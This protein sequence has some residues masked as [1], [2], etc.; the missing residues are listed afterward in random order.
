MISFV[1]EASLP[2]IFMRS[3]KLPARPPFSG[4]LTSSCCPP[5]PPPLP[6]Q[7]FL[8]HLFHFPALRKAPTGSQNLQEG[9]PRKGFQGEKGPGM[10]TD[11]PGLSYKQWGAICI[12]RTEGTNAMYTFKRELIKIQKLNWG[13]KAAW[14]VC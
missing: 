2:Q 6:K 5:A 7:W 14:V 13:T 9:T 11:H 8:L 1:Y 4:L 12:L 3:W 10:S